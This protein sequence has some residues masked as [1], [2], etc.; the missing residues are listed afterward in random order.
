M[1]IDKLAEKL[2]AP[3][4]ANGTPTEAK[5]SERDAA[6]RRLAKVWGIPADQVDEAHD[7]LAAYLNA[8]DE[9]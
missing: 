7:A 2:S 5:S 6:F 1:L 4:K 3:P 9:D 8:D